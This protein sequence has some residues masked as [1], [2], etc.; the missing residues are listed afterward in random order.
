[1]KQLATSGIPVYPAGLSQ[2]YR[3]HVPLAFKKMWHMLVKPHRPRQ[4]WPRCRRVTPQLFPRSCCVVVTLAPGEECVGNG[5]LYVCPD[6]QLKNYRSDW[7]DFC[8]HEVLYPWLGP[9]LRWSGPG[10]LLKNFTIGRE[11]NICHQSTP[12]CQKGVMMKTWI[13][14]S[15]VHHS[16][17]GSVVQYDCMYV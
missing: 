11:E 4:A 16:E 2:P 1:M 17:R 13:M 8:I 9:P 15:H 6:V 3:W 12:M 10:S 5:C 14:T 7:L